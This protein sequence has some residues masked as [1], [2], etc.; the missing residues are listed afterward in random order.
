MLFN[1]GPYELVVIVGGFAAITVGPLAAAA[2]VTWVRR[3]RNA[4]RG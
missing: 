1:L 3:R 4:P 2:V